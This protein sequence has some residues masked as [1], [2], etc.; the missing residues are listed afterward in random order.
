VIP[1]PSPG[2][3]AGKP[4]IDTTR[5]V[6]ANANPVPLNASPSVE[7]EKVTAP[8]PTPA[9]TVFPPLVFDAKALVGLGDR[10]NEREVNVQLAD[11]YLAVTAAAS[12]NDVIYRQPF[13][14]IGSIAYSMS[15]HPLWL[16]PDGPAPAART[17]RVLGIFARAR[18]WLTLRGADATDPATIVLRFEN[19]EQVKHVVS[20]LT[21]R[22]GRTAVRVVEPKEP[23]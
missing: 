1:Q 17:G 20:A 2:Q 15:R 8:V 13:K 4:V 22:T 23:K 6:V 21:E 10:Q 12:P 5:P 16:S 3:A 11:G 19:A 18:H 7:S 14:G 9:P